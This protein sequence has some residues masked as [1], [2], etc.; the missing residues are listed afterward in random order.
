MRV[1][2]LAEYRAAVKGFGRGESEKLRESLLRMM[3]NRK[4]RLLPK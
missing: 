2:A 3:K 1:A 4:V